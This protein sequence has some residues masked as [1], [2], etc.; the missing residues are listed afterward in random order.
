MAKYRLD[1]LRN[2]RAVGLSGGQKRLL[3]FARIAAARPRLTILDEPM[4][5]VNPVLGE[6]I[7]QAIRDLRAAGSTVVVV[8]HNL[9]FIERTC[10]EVVVM[11][12]GSVIA[13]GP[14]DQLRDNKRVVDAYLGND[15]E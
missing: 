5:G 15:D 3:E 10:D 8:E 1:A 12:L 6:R 2:N 7:G 13:Q 4:G 14:F 9:P 11:D